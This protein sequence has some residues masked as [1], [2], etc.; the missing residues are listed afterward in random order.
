MR[1]K[2]EYIDGAVEESNHITALEADRYFKVQQ[3]EE[4]AVSYRV[5][6]AHCPRYD[7]EE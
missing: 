4:G 2:I 7:E 3:E 5:V 1:I 6:P